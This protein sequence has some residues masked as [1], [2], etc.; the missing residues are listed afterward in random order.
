MVYNNKK[1][2]L[3]V[4]SVAFLFF[5]LIILAKNSKN[6]IDEEF[7]KDWGE[8]Q[9]SNQVDKTQ[10]YLVVKN[11]FNE[12]NLDLAISEAEKIVEKDKNDL[13]ALLLLWTS[14]LQKG[15]IEFE[16]KEYGKKGLDIAN[17]ILAIDENSDE[18]YVV[19][20]YAYEIMENYEKSIESYSKGIEI[21]NKNV[22]LYNHRGHAYF[23]MWNLDKA[24]IDV[25]KALEIEPENAYGLISKSKYL[26]DLKNRKSIDIKELETNLNLVLELEEVLNLRSKA[27]VYQLLG[28]AKSLKKDF[29]GAIEMFEKSVE[30]D[31][32]FADWWSGL[33]EATYFSMQ[34][35]L[36]NQEEFDSKF[37]E[38]LTYTQKAIDI[39]ENSST[40]YIIMAKVMHL[41]AN[42]NSDII[43]QILKKAEEVVVNDIS[44]SSVEKKSVKL[45]ILSLRNK[46]NLN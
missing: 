21:N 17:K 42:I 15:S 37:W 6:G 40:A 2:I 1:W 20:G 31:E 7:V 30:I 34:D 23:L 11:A 43:K 3:L 32:N 12:N 25:N 26:L 28:I 27:E 16:E 24:I 46:W 45:D 35:T 39:Y 19:M 38:V 41:N 36:D 4:F 10:E 22:S 5:V 44:L 13:D 14:F 18:W 8:N 9:V 33:A 29:N